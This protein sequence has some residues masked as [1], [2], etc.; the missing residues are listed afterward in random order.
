MDPFGWLRADAWT[1]GEDGPSHAKERQTVI[2]R[3]DPEKPIGIMNRLIKVFPIFMHQ[4]WALIQLPL[5]G[6]RGRSRQCR[7]RSEE[8]I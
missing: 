2:G 6:L 8:Q 4:R 5:P 1:G 3:F 7:G